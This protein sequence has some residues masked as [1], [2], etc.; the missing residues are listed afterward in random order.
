MRRLTVIA[1]SI[2]VAV[3]LVVAVLVAMPGFRYG[4]FR[5]AVELPQ[6]ATYFAIR[7][8][9][10]DQD[11]KTVAAGLE[12]QMKLADMLGVK[13]STLLPGIVE[14][15][16]FVM[17]RA[18]VANEYKMLL[19]FL[20]ALAERHPNLHLA[21]LWLGRALA[22]VAPGEAFG[23]LEAA[24]RL[25]P[26]DDQVYRYAVSAAFAVGQEKTAM[27]WCQRYAKAQLGGPHG[28]RYNNIFKGTGI[29]KMAL[30][31]LAKD[32]LPAYI[33]HEGI[34][35]ASRRNYDFSLPERLKLT[36]I[37]LHAAL[38][39]GVSVQFH[40][41][42]V[43]GPSGIR[44]LPLDSLAIMP[45]FGFATGAN[46]FATNSIDGEL[47]ILQNIGEPWGEIDRIDFEMTFDRLALNNLPGCR[48]TSE[49]Q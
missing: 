26:S 16:E 11:F 3:A 37:A 35:L 29:R 44:E 25:M 28:Y 48:R 41:V 40:K 8:P 2:L 30:E 23:P 34:Q 19:P 15:T 39:S 49:S 5:I 4:I 46:R 10:Y 47:Y 12:R 33:S 36:R 22:S 14:N 21:Q 31:V 6:V 20:R 13:R 18:R 32:G 1:L 17:D 24:A 45:M 38:V 43:Y 27:T 7:G 42:T 9:L